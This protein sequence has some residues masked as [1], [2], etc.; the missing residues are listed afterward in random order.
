MTISFLQMSCGGVLILRDTQP[1]VPEDLIQ[2]L[3]G[4]LCVECISQVIII[5]SIL[6]TY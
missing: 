2:P 1:E 4:M 5:C 6:S 3:K